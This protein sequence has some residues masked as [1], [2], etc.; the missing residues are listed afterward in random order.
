[1]RPGINARFVFM[2]AT[3]LT[4]TA[5]LA[6][7]LASESYAYDP[8]GRLSDI[9]YPNG[10][11]IHYT[12]DANGNL[13]SIV[14]SLAVTGVDDGGQTLEFALGPTTPNPGTGPRRMAFTIPARGRVALRVF[15][16]FGR[17]VATLYNR[18]LDPGRYNAQFSTSRWASGVYFYRLE[19][20]SRVRTGRLV[21]LR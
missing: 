3:A 16:V 8:V 19:M 6:Q 13:L 15:D 20:G 17:E 2:I 7:A 5:W 12:Y 4:L 14:T 9:S 10:G 1:M 21:V 11:S 18:V